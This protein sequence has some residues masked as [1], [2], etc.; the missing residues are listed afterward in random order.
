MAQNL[1]KYCLVTSLIGI[2]LFSS[3]PYFSYYLIFKL[4]QK[5]IAKN[6]C[7]ERDNP[8]NECLGCCQLKKVM[9]EESEDDS[10][11]EVI[12][13]PEF[14]ISAILNYLETEYHLYQN[15]IKFFNY[16]INFLLKLFY[17]PNTPP[18]EFN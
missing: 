11:N 9:V 15:S 2:I 4:N 12:N 10:K 5:Y 14:S 13:F 3:S 17:K 1:L 8:E 6:L 16:S 18:P 7:V